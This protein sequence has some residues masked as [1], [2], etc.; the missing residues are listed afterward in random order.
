[1]VLFSKY[2]KL[3]QIEEK[4]PS[5]LGLDADPSAGT[6]F[7]LHTV[8][9]VSS[10]ALLLFIFT[11]NQLGPDQVEALSNTLQNIDFLNIKLSPKLIEELS[12]AR[13]ITIFILSVMAAYGVYAVVDLKQRKTIQLKQSD[14]SYFSESGDI[15]YAIHVLLLLLILVSSFLHYHPKPK[16]QITEIEFIPNQI[17]SRKAPKETKRRAEKQSVSAGKHNPKKPV[18]PITQPTGKPKTAPKPEVKAEPVK[19]TESKP[20][21]KPPQPAAPRPMPQAAKPQPSPAPAPKQTQVQPKQSTFTPNTFTPPTPKPQVSPQALPREALQQARMSPKASSLPTPKTYSSTGGTG[22]SAT[23][24]G[25]SPAPKFDSSGAGETT[26]LV[27]RIA[28]I[29]RA[30]SMGSGGAY[31]GPSNPDAND[32]PNGPASLGAK[33][34]ADFG[35]YMSALQRRIKMAWKPPRGTESNRIVV[36]FTVNRTGYL[37]NVQLVTP[38]RDQSANA[39]ALDAVKRAAPFDP[40]PAGSPATIDIEFTFDYNVFKKERW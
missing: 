19:Q 6:K 13:P 30:P 20:T 12:F 35:P 11:L 33:S 25:T 27:A 31:G 5:R 18:T 9:A 14:R 38:S 4:K 15:S 10:L 40:L 26:N 37:Q 7:F 8:S 17:E 1:M 16:I 39:A 36:V 24:S 23:G 32:N 3:T 28:S 29:P 34:D 21:P 2:S 22:S